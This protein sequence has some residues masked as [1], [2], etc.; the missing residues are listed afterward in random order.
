MIVKFGEQL[1]CTNPACG[2]EAV[3]Q[4]NTIEGDNPHCVCS[5]PMRKNCASPNFAYLEFLSVADP[6]AVPEGSRKG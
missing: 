6:V 5:A 3:V 4:S 1:H 2:C